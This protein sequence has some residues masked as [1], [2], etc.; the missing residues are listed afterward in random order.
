MD[1]TLA[2]M[3]SRYCKQSMIV[4]RN[5][6]SQTVLGKL[7]RCNRTGH[8][9][10]LDVRASA[11]DFGR[12]ALRDAGWDESTPVLAVCPINPF[13]WP[14][15][16]SVAR[17][18]AKTLTGAYKESHY[19]SVY[20]HNAGPKVTPAYE[21]YL[22]A[23]SNAVERFRSEHNVFVVLVA[24]ESLDIDACRRMSEKLGGLPSSGPRS[25][26]CISSSAYLRGCNLWSRPAFMGS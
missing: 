13:W 9:Y 11:S 2:K 6:E 21:D 7:G 22:S 3:C 24:M 25:M 5:E 15:K 4:T 20:F 8:R 16:A 23:M 19:R 10:G 14:V 12:K 18:A 26:T 1:P 17:L